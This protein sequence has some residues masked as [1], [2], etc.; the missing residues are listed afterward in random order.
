MRFL[1][2]TRF[3]VCALQS[4]RHVGQKSMADD[5]EESVKQNTNATL[6]DSSSDDDDKEI[7][8]GETEE[9]VKTFKDLVS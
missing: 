6:G 9:P 4:W 7:Y 2:Q 8:N 5:C 3:R 1:A